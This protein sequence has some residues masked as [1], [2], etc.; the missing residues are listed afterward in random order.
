MHHHLQRRVVE[1]RDSA[2]DEDGSPIEEHQRVRPDPVL[3]FR[4]HILA[5]IKRAHLGYP[6]LFLQYIIFLV[7]NC[8]ERK[9]TEVDEGEHQDC[10]DF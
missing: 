6:L 9:W 10:N 7:E 2:D 3:P 1:E 4:F 5:F 8:G